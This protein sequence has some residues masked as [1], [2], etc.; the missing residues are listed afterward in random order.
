MRSTLPGR[1][2]RS[3]GGVRVCTTVLIRHAG[4]PTR[5]PASVAAATDFGVRLNVP[6]LMAYG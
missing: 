6:L 3:Y 5:V 1:V 4:S 2:A